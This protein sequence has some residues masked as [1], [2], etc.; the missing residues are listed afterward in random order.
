MNPPIFSLCKA[1][2]AVTALLG[3]APLRLY[4]G[5]ADEGTAYPYAIW[6]GIGGAPENY[7]G[8]LPNIDGYSLQIDCWA[9]T[10]TA[11]SNVAKAI[12][13]A[14]EGRA[15]VVSNRGLSRDPETK[16]YRYSFDVDWLVER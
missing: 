15:Y 7:L 10:A 16:H 4:P 8:G 13:D 1:S 9:E 5:E 12:R 11:A 14:I 6:Q 3:S 2:A